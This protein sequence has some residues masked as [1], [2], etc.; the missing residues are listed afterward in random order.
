MK[1]MNSGSASHPKNY[2]A[3]GEFRARGLAFILVAGLIFTGCSSSFHTKVSGSLASF[4]RN[5][6]VAIL[7]IETS[8]KG[9]NEAANLFRRA[10]Y[11]N[12][13]QAKYQVMERYAV[14]A[15]LKKE[16]LTDPAD[17]L[18]VSPMRLGEILGVDAVIMSR[19]EKVQRL[20]LVLHASIEVAVSV[21]M[22]DTR[23]GEVLW[24]ADRAETAFEG[25]AKIPTGMIA[26]GYG[27][28]QFITNKVNLFK[29][30]K[31]IA[32][33]ITALL[34]N[35]LQASE[36]EKYDHAVITVAALDDLDAIN[37]G[38]YIQELGTQVAAFHEE[39]APDQ[40]GIQVAKLE[41]ID[42]PA[43]DKSSKAPRFP[44]LEL[45]RGA[46]KEK[47]AE[48]EITAASAEDLGDIEESSFT[49]E[50]QFP[51]LK[52]EIAGPDEVFSARTQ[53]AEKA[54]EKFIPEPRRQAEI[55]LASYRPEK[56][57][58]VPS[59]PQAEIE[60]EPAPKASEALEASEKIKRRM[61]EIRNAQ[62]V[63]RTQPDF[64]SIQVGAFRTQ[65]TAYKMISRLTA[66]GYSAF[67][68]RVTKDDGVSLYKVQLEKFQSKEEARRFGKEFKTKENMDNFITQVYVAQAASPVSHS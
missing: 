17:Y 26:A 16:G 49:E 36:E 57:Q 11:A 20:Y 38:Q 67:I 51:E 21:Q 27:P 65:T 33:S 54:E 9:Q 7:P 25:I 46:Y 64:Y 63:K 52:E 22:V 5:H 30:T 28:L 4:S 42:K 37:S 3:A 68:N 55:Q 10:L 35:P 66:K 40:P 43:A 19:M 29:V 34:K 1:F 39:A 53:I 15:L 32:N 23:S 31:G 6:V 48:F 61:A 13:K 58:P 41:A 8:G 24:H 56:I 45:D 44:E 2:T 62:R 59:A 14:D 18:K 60:R 50:K 12:L 47:R